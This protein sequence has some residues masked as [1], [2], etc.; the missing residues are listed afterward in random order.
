MNLEA[1]LELII[2]QAQAKRAGQANA[3]G[4]ATRP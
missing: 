4:A 3:G 2:A 1:L